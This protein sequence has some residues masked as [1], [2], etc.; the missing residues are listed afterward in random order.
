MEEDSYEVSLRGNNLQTFGYL[1]GAVFRQ[2]LIN[3]GLSADTHVYDLPRFRIRRYH[4][5]PS[6]IYVLRVAAIYDHLPEMEQRVFLTEFLE[7]GRHYPFWYLEVCE[8]MEYKA[9]CKKTL[10]DISHLMKQV[11]EPNDEK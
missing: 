6:G 3:V 9:I 1:V 8:P 7:K 5:T 2:C 4:A 11:E 10:S